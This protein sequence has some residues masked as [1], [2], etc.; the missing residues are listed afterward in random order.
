M[1]TKICKT[2]ITKERYIEVVSVHT[3]TKLIHL[4]QTKKNTVEPDSSRQSV[5]RRYG[6]V[7][8]YVKQCGTVR[9]LL[10]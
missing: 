6:F 2:V 3:D 10:C 8:G 7:T 4:K 9:S 5:R 1:P